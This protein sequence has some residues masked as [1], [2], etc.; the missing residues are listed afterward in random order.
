M[1]GRLT[2]LRGQLGA[3]I[4]D[5]NASLSIR[6]EDL[7]PTVA[8]AVK[9]GQVQKFEF[10]IELFWKTVKAVLSEIHG[11]DIASPKPIIKKWYE[12]GFI[13]YETCEAILAGLDIR[14]ELSHMYK[15]EMFEKVHVEIKKYGKIFQSALDKF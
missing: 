12:L 2:A 13:P 10:T 14:N 6:L 7:D 11:V 3:A 1:E 4:N 15:K 9:N 5:F 8:D